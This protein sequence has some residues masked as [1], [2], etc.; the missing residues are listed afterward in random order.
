[1]LG[2]ASGR[3]YGPV[4]GV[5]QLV[6]APACHA[7]GRGIETRLHRQMYHISYSKHEKI[8]LGVCIVIWVAVLALIV[9]TYL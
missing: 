5:A 9:F 2:I 1:M 7:G 4:G 3:G 6:R 8:I